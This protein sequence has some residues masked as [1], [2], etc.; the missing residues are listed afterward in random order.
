MAGAVGFLGGATA[1]LLGVLMLASLDHYN[2]TKAIVGDE[3]LANSASFESTDGLPP[4]DQSKI[5]RDLICLMRSVATKSWAA[6]E[7]ADL[8]GSDHTHAWRRRASA[9]ANATIPRTKAEEASLQVLKSSLI[10][11]SY[12]GQQRLLSAESV[13]SAL[14]ILVFVSFFVLMALLTAL[15][16]PHPSRTLAI[17]GLA[18]VLIVSTAM[19]WTLTTFDEPFT[20]GDGVYISPRAL[21]AVMVRLEATYPEAD[22]GP[23]EILPRP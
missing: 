10:N 18:A 6:A 12:S 17:A 11:A 4:A 2:G 7:A 1:F 23:C 21:N 19:L 14:W 16:I 3:A 9:H 13:P 22:W 15:L 8:T 5:Q 20:Q